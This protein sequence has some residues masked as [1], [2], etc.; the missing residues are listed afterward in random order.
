MELFGNYN[1]KYSIKFVVLLK[2]FTY[3]FLILNPIKDVCTLEI[4]LNI[5]YEEDGILNIRY[6]RLMAKHELKKD[7]YKTGINKKHFTNGMNK[8]TKN[9]VGNIS[10]YSY[11]KKDGLTELDAYKKSYKNRQ[12]K[13][14]A[15]G[16]LECYCEKIVFDKIGYIDN[17][18]E[19][20]RNDKNS[21]KKKIYNKICYLLIIF[22]F[23]PFLG[24]VI[25]LFFQ[26][27]NPYLKGLCFSD[28][29]DKHGK[30]DDAEGH[31]STKYTRSMISE[32]EWSII[33][34]MNKVFLY[35]SIIFVLFVVIYIL[36]KVIKYERLKSGKGIIKGTD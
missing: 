25:P 17:L 22:A 4:S 24:L 31:K 3:I 27:Y 9:E 8:I 5:N 28:C 33:T 29:K 30:N 35:L 7:L 26:E 10:P 20:M 15:L 1:L 19:K 36:I 11:L 13:K 21:F 2:F 6:N 18:S 23:V 16:K 34:T 32:N 14:N 12:S